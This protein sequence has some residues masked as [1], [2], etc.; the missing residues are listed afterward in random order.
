MLGN[1]HQ[2]IVKCRLRVRQSVWWPGMS[3]QIQEI[4]QNCRFYRVN[5]KPSTEPLLPSTMPE[6]SWE[7]LGADLIEF[8]KDHYLVL[9]D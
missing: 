7:R 6:R 1:L 2:S 3:T 9:V 4:I 5:S 8:Q